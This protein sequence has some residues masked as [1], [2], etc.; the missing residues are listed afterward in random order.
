M[1]ALGLVILVV[2]IVSALYLPLD[3][4]A[5]E[6]KEITIN[7]GDGLISVANLLTKENIIRNRYIFIVY[8]MAAGNERSI[9]AGKYRV[10]SGQ[11]IP[12]IV[13]VL[14]SGLAVAEGVRITIP[15]GLNVFEINRIV[16]KAGVPKSGGIMKTEIIASEGWLFPDTYLF[17]PDDTAEDIAKRMRDNFDRKIKELKDSGV[18]IPDA[19][20]NEIIIVASILEKEVRNQADMK[21]VA[22]VIDKRLE[23]DMPLELDATVAYGV[24]LPEYISG[25]YCDVSEVNLVDNIKIDSVYNTY[26]RK[27]LPA[28]PISNPGLMSIIAALNPEP[29]D[30]LY[31]LSAENGETI[32]SKTAAE[33]IK[34]RQKYLG[35]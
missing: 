7:K 32:F 4:S 27:G 23:L 35:L 34:A 1:L 18:Q 30:Y 10:S 12:K 22:G 5:T 9:K 3:R 2:T 21:L 33:H 29:S 24:C 6:T 25:H 11:N 13:K 14:S 8:A 26:S 17:D 15:E 20:L 16:I 28:G 31:Y 19:K